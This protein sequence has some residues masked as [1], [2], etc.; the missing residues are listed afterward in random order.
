VRISETFINRP[1]ATSLFVAG[2]ALFGVVAYRALPVSDFPA[3]GY[4]TIKVSPNLPGGD[5]DVMA[6]AIASPLERQFT[7]IA[8]IDDGN[9][10]ARLKAGVIIAVVRFVARQNPYTTRSRRFRT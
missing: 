10:D 9:Q 1:I 2:T 7:S 8:G 5:P 3:V 6:S 4:P